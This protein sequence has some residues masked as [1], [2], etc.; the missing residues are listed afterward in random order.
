[1]CCSE[2][3]HVKT[4][5]AE[6]SFP[7]QL[8]MFFCLVMLL[9]RSSPK[10]PPWAGCSLQTK[11]GVILL[12]SSSALLWAAA[13]SVGTCSSPPFPVLSAFLKLYIKY[14]LLLS[15]VWSF[16]G[17]AA[18]KPSNWL[19]WWSNADG[20]ESKALVF[21]ITSSPLVPSATIHQ[22]WHFNDPFTAFPLCLRLAE[23]Q[24]AML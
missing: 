11:A 4:Y 5:E 15:H 17:W 23:V 13:Y 9:S 10:P 14:R 3:V 6:G 24:E 22:E 20:F 8:Y 12:A 1:M 2:I 18:P 21:L 7:V 19:I 16:A